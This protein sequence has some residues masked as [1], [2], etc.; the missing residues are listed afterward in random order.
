MGSSSAT[1]PTPNRGGEA[2]AIQII[3]NVGQML[4]HAL[5]QAG[6][7]SELGGKILDILK[8][9]NKLSPPGSTSPAANKNVMD[10]AQLRNAQQNQMAQQMRQRMM[11]GGGGGGGGGPPGAEAGGGGPPMAA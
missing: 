7:T 2:A 10:Q 3:G 1:T 6:A 4:T 5:T 9:I 8:T 11:Q